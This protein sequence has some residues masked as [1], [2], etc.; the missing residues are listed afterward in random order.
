MRDDSKLRFSIFAPFDGVNKDQRIFAFDSERTSG[1]LP[2]DVSG[3]M[4]KRLSMGNADPNWTGRLVE[5]I[6]ITITDTRGARSEQ[7]TQEKWEALP[8][9]ERGDVV[10]FVRDVAGREEPVDEATY[11]VLGPDRQGRRVYY[12]RELPRLAEVDAWG[13]GDNIALGMLETGGGIEHTIAASGRHGQG[14]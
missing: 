14:L 1:L 13:W 4:A 7:I 6:R 9:G 12:R 10:Y 11:E 2:A 3:L 5:V 8:E